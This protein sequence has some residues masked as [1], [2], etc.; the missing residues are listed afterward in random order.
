MEDLIFTPFQVPCPKCAKLA[1]VTIESLFD[2]EEVT[3]QKCSFI[4]LPNIDVDKL[5]KLL[6]L[7]ENSK[8]IQN[9]V[10]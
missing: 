5:L 1:F 8:I 7:V 10:A 6:K 2:N 3:C 4:F 9:D